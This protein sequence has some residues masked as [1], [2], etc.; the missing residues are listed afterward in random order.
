MPARSAAIALI[1]CDQFYGRGWESHSPRG[2]WYWLRE[3]MEGREK[4]TQEQVNRFMLCTTCEL[5]NDRCSE[6]L[7]IEPDWMKLRGK[8]IT[9]KDNG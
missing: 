5:C 2:K 8:L 3:Y 9:D 6:Y 7:P 1:R 4:M